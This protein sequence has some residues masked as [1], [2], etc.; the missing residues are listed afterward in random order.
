MGKSAEGAAYS[1]IDRR[2]RDGGNDLGQV[3][4]ATALGLGAGSWC[5]GVDDG[6]REATGTN[7]LNDRGPAGR[8]SCCRRGAAEVASATPTKSNSS[9]IGGPLGHMSTPVKTYSFPPDIEAEVS[10]VPT[11]QGGRSTPAFSGYRPQFYY[12]DHNWDADHEYPD[13]EFVLP[14]ETARALLRFL[15]PDAQVGRVHPGM[16]FQVREGAR[17]VALGRVTKI[18]HLVESEERVMSKR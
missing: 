11:E 12:D 13:V 10:F 8:T 2:R 4:R 5:E 6:P 3:R 18:L 7:R 17:I 14:G 16:E 1:P 15:S 9:M